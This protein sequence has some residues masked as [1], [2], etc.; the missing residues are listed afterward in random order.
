MANS[1]IPPYST[2]FEKLRSAGFSK[3]DIER[4]V[5]KI[6]KEIGEFVTSKDYHILMVAQN[7]KVDVG[8]MKF[9]SEV[10]TCKINEI[11]LDMYKRIEVKGYVVTSEKRLSRKGND[12]I[13]LTVADETGVATIRVNGGTSGVGE[14]E[15]VKHGDYVRV[16][17]VQV[18]EYPKG[19]NKV[20]LSVYAPYSSVQVTN[21]DI[22]LD[23]FV[24][25][26]DTVKD[27]QLIH[28][29]GV[30]MEEREQR[31][32]LGC[33][34][35]KK[36]LSDKEVEGESVICPNCSEKVTV[37]RYPTNDVAVACEDDMITCQLSPFLNVP[38]NIF[39]S[40]VDIWGKYSEQWNRVDVITLGVLKANILQPATTYIE[41]EPKKVKEKIKEEEKVVEK[42]VEK[43]EDKEDAEQVAKE[44]GEISTPDVAETKEVTKKEEEWIGVMVEQIKLIGTLIESSVVE[45]IAGRFKLP[46][47]VVKSKIKELVKDNKLQE[48]DGYLS[49]S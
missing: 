32:Y 30:V 20:S 18:N 49:I 26:V 48:K 15:N 4:D 14:F 40:V 35:C 16:P 10:R 44:I 5:K 2:T 37:T 36:K 43:K 39:G 34:Y 41:E 38:E 25:S 19:S 24:T 46:E 8:E 31:H 7:L 17:S 3:E 23:D 6:K 1:K 33:S 28:V 42:A 11:T 9:I 27:G 22:P 21:P 29:K 12:M 45:S 13:F 47:D